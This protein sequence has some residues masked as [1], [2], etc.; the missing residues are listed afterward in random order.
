MEKATMMLSFA[1]ITFLLQINAKST[2]EH[3]NAHDII[4][5][6]N[7]R[8]FAKRGAKGKGTSAEDNIVKIN[9]AIG[10]DLFEGDI[11]ISKDELKSLY[12]DGRKRNIIKDRRNIWAT[13]IVPYRFDASITYTNQQKVRD[14]MKVIVK[15]VPCLTF[16]ERLSSDLYYIRFYFGNGCWSHIGRQTHQQNTDVSLSTHCYAQSTIIHEIMHALGFFHEQSRPDRDS[17][18]T[19]Y[20]E[21]IQAINKY[22]F[23]RQ[24]AHAGLTQGTPYDYKS[25]MHYSR[26]TFTM[27]GKDTIRAKFD[28]EMPLGGQEMS[29]YDIL[30]LNKAYQCHLNSA[31]KMSDWTPWTVCFPSGTTCRKIRQRYCFSETKSDCPGADYTGVIDEYQPCSSCLEPMDGHW[32]NWGSWGACTMSCGEGTRVRSRVCNNPVPSN[33]GKACSGSNTET[34]ICR[35]KKCY[36]KWYDTSFEDGWGM[37]KQST[38]DSGLN[39]IR[40]SGQTPSA[41]TGPLG[42]HTS[43]YGYY[44][45]VEAGYLDHKKSV[46]LKSAELPANFGDKCL[47]FFYNMNGKNMGSLTVSL[48]FKSGSSM[49]LWERK[50]HQGLEWKPAGINLA[51]SNEPYTILIDAKI[52]IAPESDIAID[53]I[54]IDDG[55]CSR[56]IEVCK[57]HDNSCPYWAKIG[58]CHKN[59]LWMLRSCCKS[60][61]GSMG[62]CTSDTYGSSCAGYAKDYGCNYNGEW[63][64]K[65][66][67]KSC[68]D[69]LDSHTHCPAWKAAGDCDR[70]SDWM[71]ANCKM[72]C[73]VC[74]PVADRIDSSSELEIKT[75]QG[76]KISLKNA[77]AQ[78]CIIIINYHYLSYTVAPSV[79][80]YYVFLLFIDNYYELFMKLRVAVASLLEGRCFEIQSAKRK[81]SRTM[82]VIEKMAI[83]G[84]RSYN[85]NEHSVIE[86]Q[87]PLTLLVGQ[88]GCGKTTVIEC[89][90]YV[91]TGDMPPGSKNSAFIHDPKVA[92][93]RDVKGQVKLRFTDVAGKRFCVIRSMVSSQKLKK[94]ETKSLESVISKEVNGERQS[95]SSRCADMNREMITRLGVSKAVLENVIFCHQ[96]EANWPLG[97]GK[98]LKQKFDDIFAATRYIKALESIRVFR[99]EQAQSVKVYGTDLKYLK[100]RKEESEQLRLD[101][102]DKQSKME[103]I[104]DEI[105][106]TDGKIEPIETKLAEIE[107]VGAEVVRLEKLI[108]S[109]ESMLKQVQKNARELEDK[110]VNKFAGSYQELL[111]CN[112]EFAEKIAFEQ[113]KVQQIESK[114]RHCT[115]ELQRLNTSRTELLT[116]HG[117]LAQ[118]AESH[119]KKIVTR[120]KKIEELIE[121]Y[122]LQGLSTSPYEREQV[123]EFLQKL[124]LYYKR[125]SSDGENMRSAFQN[126]LDDASSRINNVRKS[127]HDYESTMKHKREAMEENKRKLRQISDELSS[128]TASG[129]RLQ[130]IERDLRKAEKELEELQGQV[131]S[132]QL[133]DDIKA[134]SDEKKETEQSLVRLRDEQTRMHLQSTAQTKIDMKVKEKQGKEDSIQSI[135]NRH[136]MDMD[137]MF[138]SRPPLDELKSKVSQY[139]QMK[140]AD[141]R[142]TNERVKGIEKQLA[143]KDANRRMNLEQL[144]KMEGKMAEYKEKLSEACGENDYN[145]YRE[146]VTK[147][148]DKYKNVISEIKAFEKIYRKY[149][150]EMKGGQEK[151]KGCPLC[152]RH[153]DTARELHQLIDELEHKLVSV[154]EKKQQNETI[155]E[156]EKRKLSTINELAPVK[157]NLETLEMRE[158]PDVRKKVSDLG[159]EIE[160]LKEQLTDLEDLRAMSESE[161]RTARDMEPDIRMVDSYLYEIK[162]IDK[163]INLESSKLKGIAPGRTITALTNE[164]QEAQ[165]KVDS[166]ERKLELKR[167]Q[168]MEYNR[169]CSVLERSVNEWTSQKLDITSKL[170]RRS[171]LEEQKAE[172]SSANNSFEREIREA[173]KQLDPIKRSLAELEEKK[174]EI[175]R[176]KEKHNEE[177]RNSMDAIKFNGNKVREL[178]SEINRYISDGKELALQENNEAVTEIEEQNKKFERE[179]ERLSTDLAKIR[180]EVDT[181][182][183]RGRELEDNILL[184]KAESEIRQ[185]EREISDLRKELS[186]YGDSLNM[187]RERTE[188]QNRLDDLRKNKA[189]F[190]G[191]LKGFEDEQRRIQ[192]DLRS[193]KFAEADDKHRK[194]MIEV[195][196]TEMANQ[197]LEKYYKALD[198]AIMKFH[199]LKMAEINRI[200]KEYWIHTYRGHDI[201]TIEIRADEEA[202]S[203]AAK[204]RRTYNYRV[205]MIKGETA[206]DMR[207]RCSAGQKVLASIIIRLALAETFCLNCGILAL[208]EPTTNLD[209]QN[210]ESLANALKDIILTRQQQRNFQLVVITHDEDFVRALGQSDHVD[211]FYRV[212]KDQAGYSKIHRQ[213]VSEMRD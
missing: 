152:H 192:R 135:L 9:H 159:K 187:L 100:E 30:E 7:R 147:S 90:K 164:I 88:N 185:A 22:N 153:F 128:V 72:S 24:K 190:E 45:Y 34:N 80:I 144:R 158:L 117:K 12:G 165:E 199:G 99:R 109:N 142:A 203:G 149:I 66:C 94:I 133:N 92:G 16:R 123:D 155:L 5:E 134:L 48:L 118:E 77:T 189:S 43:H 107:S 168:M 194:K 1:L 150:T 35:I 106:K 51:N 213:K 211:H 110:I 27:N 10:N 54:Y 145:V 78:F 171:Q 132:T 126:Q 38:S 46:H 200:I 129:N 58:E 18:I 91:T 63:M 157:A 196:T 139:L 29:Q 138:D 93:E 104:R 32:G 36:Q 170:Q 127:Q 114:I 154:P 193:E 62:Q 182:K 191:R 4:M 209:E 44:A 97:E 74:K 79:V 47:V 162:D 172:L 40:H 201:D 131:N 75:Y 167:N 33:N 39:W 13:R 105:R 156:Q 84:I 42:D 83:C 60:C 25:I 20:Y 124:K 161:E 174:A 122:N 101:L 125:I 148:L 207:G 177:T 120:D 179:K 11:A 169:Q 76:K 140:K 205:V 87:T 28:P 212:Y 41:Q 50:G 183:T 31:T 112:E 59:H 137:T 23:D 8:E 37:W 141:V 96:E 121:E 67:C 202:G 178:N 73:G 98:F 186:K 198:G 69:C 143:S 15:N 49:W 116:H 103:V 2:G 3:K 146:Q 6:A 19:I 184:F 119:K 82:A 57:D 175:E 136:E 56:G 102:V 81:D 180:K 85:P 163:A 17:F 52:G 55:K 204:A 26:T 53:D 166:I 21:N 89:L 113:G 65:N 188:L 208:D 197:D 108:G 206:L 181:Q 14:A 71:K 68:K 70:Y 176:N 111:K 64:W 151:E 195:K 160:S 173:E 210:V 61:S 86:F 115:Q 130:G 95:I